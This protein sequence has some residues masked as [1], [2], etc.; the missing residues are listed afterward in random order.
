MLLLSAF[1]HMEREFDNCLQKISFLNQRILL[2]GPSG[3]SFHLFLL[4]YY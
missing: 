4:L 1:V 3:I 2:S